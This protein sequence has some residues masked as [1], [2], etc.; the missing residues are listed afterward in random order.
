[1]EFV[2]AQVR[3]PATDLGLFE[4]DGRTVKRH[5]AEIRRFFGFRR[6]TAADFDK[7]T[8]RLAG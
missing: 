4:W 2:A 1:V 6:F 5:R 8:D 7:L 3:V